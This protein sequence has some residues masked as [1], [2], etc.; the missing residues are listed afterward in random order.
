MARRNT[1]KDRKKRDRLFR[2]QN[3]VCYWC[4]MP[5]TRMARTAPG[6]VVP[7]YT[8]TLDHV[9]SRVIA[10]M[11]GVK[12]KLVAACLACNLRRAQEEHAQIE[13]VRAHLEKP[14]G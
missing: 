8:L 7:H 9:P 5:M 3:G 10:K 11:N 13:L 2:E 4:H 1:K 14:Q 12:S 6:A